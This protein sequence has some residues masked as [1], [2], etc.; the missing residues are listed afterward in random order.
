MVHPTG[1][2]ASEWLQHF[3]SDIES[4]ILHGILSLEH[5]FVDDSYWRDLLA[6]TPDYCTLYPRDQI[7]QTLS[8]G[9]VVARPTAFKIVSDVRTRPAGH[10]Q[11]FVQGIVKFQTTMAE[12]SGVFTLLQADGGIWKAWS[13]V[14]VLDHLHG[15]AERYKD[16]TSSPHR[17]FER[18]DVMEYGAVV[19]GAGQCGLGVAASL[20]NLGVPTLVVE[21]AA[22]VGNTWR[23][24]Y[25]AL[26]TNT[27][28]AFSRYH[29]MILS[30]STD[31]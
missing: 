25:K 26:E 16:G 31:L 7:Q 5:S 19:L 4:S 6:F 27:T 15:V 11:T 3:I 17:P 14:S 22:V 1:A 24:R 8:N 9:V 13:L 29:F 30:I 12:C 18:R 10:D 2:I 28:K 20:E 23:H 21:K